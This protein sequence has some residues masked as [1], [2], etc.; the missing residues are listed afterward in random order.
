M[1]NT[2][3]FREQLNNSIQKII[4]QTL[5]VCPMYLCAELVPLLN[6]RKG[7][8]ALLEPQI[9]FVPVCYNPISCVTKVMGAEFT[10]DKH[11]NTIDEILVHLF[12]VLCIRRSSWWSWGESWNIKSCTFKK[13]LKW[14]REGSD[15][16]ASSEVQKLD[17]VLPG[18]EFCELLYRRKFTQTRGELA[19]SIKEATVFDWLITYCSGN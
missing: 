5:R 13:N 12:I 15:G 4:W 9:G 3:E 11:T 19:Y 6:L 14:V 16:S 18:V 17:V 2:A 10:N 1:H 8:T 7:I